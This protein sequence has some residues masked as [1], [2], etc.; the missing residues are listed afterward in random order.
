MARITEL[1]QKL[2]KVVQDL[3]IAN[4]TIAMRNTALD[5]LQNNSR[6]LEELREWKA[7][8]IIVTLFNIL[9]L[10]KDKPDCHIKSL[11]FGNA[12]YSQ[13]LHCKTKVCAAKLLLQDID[14]KNEQTAAILKKQ[15]AQLVELEA[16]YKEEQILRKKYYN[17]IEGFNSDLKFLYSSSFLQFYCILL[18]IV[19]FCLTFD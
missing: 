11:L 12:L 7:V 5:E 16:L 4:A 15:G 17:M 3:S 13:V 6:E 2:Q 14:R 8:Y 9:F 19:N 1:E 10:V 18:T